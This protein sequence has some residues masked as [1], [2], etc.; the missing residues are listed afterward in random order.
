MPGLVQGLYLSLSQKLKVASKK[1]GKDTGTIP[2]PKKYLNRC[3]QVSNP[4]FWVKLSRLLSRMIFG[5]SCVPRC[6]DVTPAHAPQ[7]HPKRWN[8]FTDLERR[9]IL[10]E[11]DKLIQYLHLSDALR[12][13]K[14]LRI[15]MGRNASLKRFVEELG[16]KA[17][18]IE[19]N[20]FRMFADEK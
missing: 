1:T 9:R 18:R 8:E 5:P 4:A 15:A 20:S 10:R 11:K 13:V 3:L 17:E 12:K 7:F 6:C 2:D 16:V 14:K 19:P